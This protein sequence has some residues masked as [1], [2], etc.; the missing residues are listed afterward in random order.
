[1][2][3]AAS[4]RRYILGH[5]RETRQK[6]IAKVDSIH[7]YTDTKTYHMPFNFIPSKLVRNRRC[8]GRSSSSSALWPASERRCLATRPQCSREQALQLGLQGCVLSLVPR[9][10][11]FSHSVDAVTERA[12]Q[13]GPAL[14]LHYVARAGQQI[15]FNCSGHFQRPPRGSL[16][17]QE[18][19]K[20]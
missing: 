8:A 15:H 1:M 13:H 7:L 12:Q 6:S 16:G 18:T 3:S 17:P 5:A 9:P 2:C 20:Q 10:D 19:T 14:L 4:S 11:S